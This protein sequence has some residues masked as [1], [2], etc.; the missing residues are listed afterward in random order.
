[1]RFLVWGTMPIGGLL[2]GVLATVIGLRSALWVAAIG[3]CLPFLWVLGG[4]VGR[5]REIPEME[6][7]PLDAA[8]MAGT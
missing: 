7:D 4:P 8:T 6:I 1:M 3:G 5:V 2:A